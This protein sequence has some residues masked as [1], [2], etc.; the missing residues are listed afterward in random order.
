MGGIG[1]GPTSVHNAKDTT[2][3]YLH[4]DIRQWARKGLLTPGNSFDW[5]WLCDGTPIAS[6]HVEINDDCLCLS[7]RSRRSG[8]SWHSMACC[9]PVD[10]TDCNFGGHRIWLRCPTAQCR[11]R[12]ALL[13]LRD[14]IFSCRQC[15]NLTY[16]S[17]RERA[18]QRLV[19]KAEEIRSQLGW[20]TGILNPGGSGKPKGM[21]RRTYF[22]LK[23]EHD[24]AVKLVVD[25]ANSRFNLQ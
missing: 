20:P 22:R 7:Y 3:D 24:D 21:H 6:I 4:I 8:G 12:L 23:G 15:H 9:I 13:Y 17:Q 11:R 19:R 5:R 10:K 1:S 25:W 14:G 16:E 18:H 2:D